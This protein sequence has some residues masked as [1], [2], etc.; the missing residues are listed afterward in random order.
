[1]ASNAPFKPP[2]IQTVRIESNWV[3]IFW[4]EILLGL[5]IAVTAAVIADQ[6]IHHNSKSMA[7]TKTASP[8]TVPAPIDMAPTH[9]NQPAVGSEKQG[10]IYSGQPIQVLCK[11]G[12]ASALNDYH[13]SYKEINLWVEDVTSYDGATDIGIAVSPWTN[14][15]DDALLKEA[16]GTYLTDDN[17]Y[18]YDLAKDGGSYTDKER[19]IKADEI[20]RFK[21]R[22]GQIAP[23]E[24]VILHHPQFQAITIV[25]PWAKN[26]TKTSLIPK[27][28]PGTV[29]PDNVVTPNIIAP[30]TPTP[31]PREVMPGRE[32]FAGTVARVCPGNDL[33]IAVLKNGSSVAF[34]RREVIGT[35]TR[36]SVDSWHKDVLTTD[37]RNIECK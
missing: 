37:I 15:G 36:L 32:R 10:I 23:T 27:P 26:E 5:I 22:F 18:R 11:P 33:E 17:G 6:L 9:S 24:T 1:M 28:S 3:E 13:A 25:F 4:R 2:D 8:G 12:W 21:L 35:V 20:Y 34:S 14:F 19:I 31:S 29:Q 16:K 7:A 30:Y